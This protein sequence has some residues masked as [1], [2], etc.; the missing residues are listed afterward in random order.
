MY[1]AECQTAGVGGP[2]LPAV[3]QGLHTMAATAA[4]AAIQPRVA[5]AAK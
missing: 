2:V 3:A 1:C 4:G 5:A